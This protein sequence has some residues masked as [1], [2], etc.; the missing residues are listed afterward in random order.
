MNT[1]PAR[2]ILRILAVG[3]LALTSACGG[4]S[5]PNFGTY[6]R[7]IPPISNQSAAFSVF[8][9]S[10]NQEQTFFPSRP[11]AIESFALTYDTDG[12]SSN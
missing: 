2:M 8:G 1:V 5:L 9:E 4:S 11:G 7:A 6:A 12:Y 10:S 3:L